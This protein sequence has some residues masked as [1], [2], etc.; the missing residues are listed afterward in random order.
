[1]KTIQK[2]FHLTLTIFTNRDKVNEK[3]TLILK[4]IV[5]YEK[6]FKFQKLTN[7]KT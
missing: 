2:I 6:L 5:N 4:L 7:Q 1:M 3:A